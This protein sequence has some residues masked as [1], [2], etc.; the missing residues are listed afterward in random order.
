MDRT[1]ACLVCLLTAACGGG[2]V[3]PTP[4]Q[5]GLATIGFNNAGTNATP[6]VIHRESGYI[7][8]PYSGNWTVF[9]TYGHPAPY[10]GFDNIVVGY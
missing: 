10:I 1:H 2:V 8:R 4:L 5:A 3:S 7:V 9:T 6:F